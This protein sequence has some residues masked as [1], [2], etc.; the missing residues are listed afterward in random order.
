MTQK[1]T[2]NVAR[3]TWMCTSLAAEG[4]RSFSIDIASDKSSSIPLTLPE[5]R[6][7]M[8]AASVLLLAP[9]CAAECRRQSGFPVPLDTGLVQV[10]ATS[11]SSTAL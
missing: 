10:L 1:G 11:S 5:N 4:S 9:L 2:Q 3:V 7:G 6:N 8:A